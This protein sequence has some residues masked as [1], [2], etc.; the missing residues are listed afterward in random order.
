MKIRNISEKLRT[1]MAK[2][3]KN[4]PIPDSEQEENDRRMDKSL[5]KYSG[6]DG[7]R[8]PKSRYQEMSPE[9][10]K[11]AQRKSDE[12]RRQYPSKNEH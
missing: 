12:L 5:R 8:S 4:N 9:Q 10:R 1:M 6:Y 3:M 11:R 2:K 7:E